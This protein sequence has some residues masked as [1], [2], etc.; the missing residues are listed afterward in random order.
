[1]K[2]HALVESTY[3]DSIQGINAILSFNV[4]DAFAKLNKIFFGVFQDKIETLGLTKNKLSFAAEFSGTLF[5]VSMLTIGSLWVIRGKILLGQFMACYSLLA[6][7][8]PSIIAMVSAYISIQGAHIAARRLMDLLLVKQEENPGSQPF[9]MNQK[10]EIKNGTFAYP[11]GNLLFKG[12][13]LTIEKGK[14]ISLWGPSGSGKSTIVQIIERKYN[15]NDGGLFLDNQPVSIFDL[16]QYRKKI[17]VIPQ[18]IKIFNG[19]LADNILT[20]REVSNENDILTKLNRFGLTGFLQI[21]KNGFYTLLGEEGRK[22]SGGET[23]LLGLARALYSEPDVLI[24]DE[25]FSSID[26]EIEE[27][28]ERVIRE[29]LT[30]HA[31]L[32]ITHDLD[33]ILKSEF[34]YM[35]G[36]NGIVEKGVPVNLLANGQS[37]FAA[38]Y[39]KQKSYL[40]ALTAPVSF[41]QPK[42]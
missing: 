2:N 11:K 19:T 9:I 31:V 40:S 25:G 22:L 3:I 20:G 7:I 38:L 41:L 13:N 33:K 15:L 18:N 1:M 27:T 35:L 21:F 14:W 42:T 4:S 34:V 17:A 10:L 26:V 39:K 37:Y 36:Q 29:Y 16:R 28:I 32:M 12:L 24:I 6:N 8:L 30:S 23:Q 5:T